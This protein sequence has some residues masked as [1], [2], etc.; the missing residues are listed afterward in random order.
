MPS[1]EKNS[2]ETVFTSTTVSLG[3]VAETKRGLAAAGAQ[4]HAARLRDALDARQGPDALEPLLV[5]DRGVALL[6]ARTAK[7]DRDHGHVAVIESR[8]ERVCGIQRTRQQA[9]RDQQHRAE[10]NLRADQRAAQPAASAPGVRAVLLHHGVDV[11][12]RGLKRRDQAKD[13]RRR[14][15]QCRAQTRAPCDP[16]SRRFS[17]LRAGNRREQPGNQRLERPPEEQR[18]AH[19]A[20][21]AR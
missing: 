9:G 20:R 7:V 21:R 4:R 8:I 18:A 17:A 5:K 19:R 2:G 3:L 12:L 15:G 1:S 14:R 6:V 10:R 11:A 16:A 13:Q